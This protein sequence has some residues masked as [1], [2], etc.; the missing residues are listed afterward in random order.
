MSDELTVVV[1]ENS[2]Y[3]DYCNNDIDHRNED[4]CLEQALTMVQVEYV[5][6]VLILIMEQLTK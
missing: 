6:C 2:Y 3:S 4:A 5:C 1:E